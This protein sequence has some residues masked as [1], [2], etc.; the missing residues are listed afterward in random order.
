MK[1][2]L[3]LLFSLLL[4]LFAARTAV[5]AGLSCRIFN[6]LQGHH[7]YINAIAFSP[8][9]G[10]VASGDDQGQVLIWDLGK[11]GELFKKISAKAGAIKAL[12]FS[13]DGQSVIIGGSGGIGRCPRATS[14][15]S[16]GPDPGAR[17]LSA[18]ESP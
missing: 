7:G 17:C 13:P 1:R 3:L 12:A 4:V 5:S 11:D 14:A 18:A 9:G 15:L 8:D 16:P 2:P 6:E 10:W